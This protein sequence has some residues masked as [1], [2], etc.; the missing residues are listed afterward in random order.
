ML[1]NQL[2]RLPALAA[3]LERRRVAVIVSVGIDLALAAKVTTTTIPI[4]FATAVDPVAVGL[5]SSLNRRGAN[6]T[7]IGVLA[8]ELA[9]KRLPLVHDVIPNAALFGVPRPRLERLQRPADMERTGR[10]R[11]LGFPRRQYKL[12]ECRQWTKCPVWSA[13]FRLKDSGW[14]SHCGSNQ[15]SRVCWYRPASLVRLSR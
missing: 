13:L 8:I 9:P 2:G 11:A 1:K 12:R 14:S 6:V 5:V 15:A 10:T 7:C 3:D 4:V